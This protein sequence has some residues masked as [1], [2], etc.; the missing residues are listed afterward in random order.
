MSFDSAPFD[1]SGQAIRV[2]TFTTLF[3][4][5]EQRGHGIFVENRLRHLVASGQ[6]TARVIAPIPWLPP[7]L[8]RFLPSY[9]ALPRVPS[10]ETRWGISVLH[11]R[12]PVIPK[13]GMTVSPALLAARALPAIHHLRRTSGDFDLIDAHYLYP[14]GVA[15]VVLGKLLRKPV[16][17]TARGSDVNLLP[18]YRLPRR[19]I[20]YAARK[21]DG[22]VTVSTALKDGLVAL[23][24][25][26]SQI[27]VL[28][29]GVDLT[30]F[31]PRDRT[32]AR[33]RLALGS[34]TLLCVGN[35]VD[36]KGHDLVIG[37]LPALASYSLLIAGEGPE[38]P[39]LEQLAARLGVAGRV[40]FLGRIQHDQLPELYSAADVL[41]LA[42]SREGWPNVLLEAM[43]CG[44]PVVASRVSGIPEIVKR[45]EAGELMTERTTEGVAVAV[46]ALTARAPQR[47][48][49]R[50]Y[51][52]GFSWDDTTH[53]QI[54]LFT[55]I[56]SRPAGVV[57]TQSAES[58][59]S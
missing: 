29:N 9:A 40:R 49:T 38:R 35:L 51:A 15:A 52:E 54:R 11:P 28:R 45:P 8:A 56:L 30:M 39:A 37:A 18:Q 58:L 25:P 53:G 2:V 19:M 47:E 4:N 41:V 55:E 1:R 34:P 57:L 21:A 48:A 26:A 59:R 46:R 24:V 27:R 13:I 20:A 31:R 10:S 43:A 16:V 6:V 50:R 36:L 14:D 32:A 12:F 23:G 33:A 3:P 42:S 17:I 5:A 7:A 22:V 44:T